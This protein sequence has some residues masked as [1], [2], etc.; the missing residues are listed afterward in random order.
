MPVNKSTYALIK[1]GC[2]ITIS[3]VALEA[4]GYQFAFSYTGFYVKYHDFIL[5]KEGHYEPV[6][7]HTPAQRYIHMVNR[8]KVMDTCRRHQAG[9]D[10]I[11]KRGFKI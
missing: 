3:L 1:A 10:G 4:A 6:K 8:K 5:S 2:P 9:M 11:K 7:V